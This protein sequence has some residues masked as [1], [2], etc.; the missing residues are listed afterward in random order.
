VRR[1]PSTLVWVVALGL[2]SS[3]AGSAAGAGAPEPDEFE[4]LLP[5]LVRV[6]SLYRDSALKFDCRESMTYTVF[7]EGKHAKKFAYLFVYDD[8]KGFGDYRLTRRQLKKESTQEKASP[9]DFGIRVFLK[10]AYLFTLVF[11]ER[12]L[13]FHQYSPEGEEFVLGRRAIRI[14]VEPLPP[15]RAGWNDWLGWYW[16]D[17]ETTQILKVEA[18]QDES[19]I[20]WVALQADLERAANSQ[21]DFGR[22]YEI[23]KVTVEFGVEKNGMRFP[24]RVELSRDGYWVRGGRPDA[25]RKARRLALTTQ[26]YSNYRFFEI[27]T[28][29]EITA[30]VEGGDD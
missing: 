25:S 21:Q 22:W 11:D 3:S 16:V 27:K 24:S 8:E 4:R 23:K 17:S 2:V 30:Y 19:A 6:A 14:F 26:V 20:A 28:A 13:P 12:L 15:M 10:R 7:G 1:W 5:R 9:E 29:E 18:Y